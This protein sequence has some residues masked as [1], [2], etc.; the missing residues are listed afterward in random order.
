M[1]Y[2]TMEELVDKCRVRRGNIVNFDYKNLYFTCDKGHEQ[3]FNITSVKKRVKL[4]RYIKCKKIS[5]SRASNKLK[6]HWT[7]GERRLGEVL[8]KLFNIDFIKVRPNWLIN[9]TTG[10]NLELDF[11]NEEYKIA[12]EYQERHHYD[13]IYINHAKVKERDMVKA[14]K[15]KELGIKLFHIPDCDDEQIL[16]EMIITVTGK[17]VPVKIRKHVFSHPCWDANTLILTR[18]HSMYL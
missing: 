4:N 2:F 8:K 5:C 10:K 6:S 3:S 1:L 13:N 15:C 17:I 14:K 12:F 18:R 11:Y 7:I 16:I 9:P